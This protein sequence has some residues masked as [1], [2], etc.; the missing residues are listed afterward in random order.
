MVK[1]Y[2]KPKHP[3]IIEPFAGGASYSLVWRT[4]NVLLNELNED[5]CLIWDWL[6]T[7]PLK[8]ILKAIPKNVK[9][10]TDVSEYL[11]TEHHPGLRLFLLSSFLRGQMGR[12]NYYTKVSSWCESR[13]NLEIPRL[14]HLIPHIQHWKIQQGSYRDLENVEATW[15]IDPPYD[16]SHGTR[17]NAKTYLKNTID[18]DHLAKWCKRRK[19]QVIVCESKGANWLPFYPLVGNK[20]GRRNSTEV[21]WTN[22]KT[23]LLF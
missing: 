7:T 11:N 8:E 23:G 1:Y 21:V 20:C 9:A 13:W 16:K 2:P 6:L 10:G 18:Y 14:K 17:P 22:E 12:A 19:G 3:L 5:S 15:F 4:K